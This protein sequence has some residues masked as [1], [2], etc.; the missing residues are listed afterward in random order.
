[1]SNTLF[2]QNTL[3]IITESINLILDT[4]GDFYSIHSTPCINRGDVGLIVGYVPST[5]KNWP[6][7]KCLKSGDRTHYRKVL[8][9]EDL[10]VVPIC[11][12]IMLDDRQN[13]R[14]I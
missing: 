9:K 12:M 13:W 4:M 7:P 5:F 6:C 11:V 14:E 1:M 8:I 2:K 10:L 3:I